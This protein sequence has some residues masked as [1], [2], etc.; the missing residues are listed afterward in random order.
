LTGARPALQAAGMRKLSMLVLG[1]ALLCF[2]GACAEQ[3]GQK[4]DDKKAD[5]KKDDKKDANKDAKK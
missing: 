2:S 5:A 4:K 3:K 1:S